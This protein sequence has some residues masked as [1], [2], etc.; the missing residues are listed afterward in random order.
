MAVTSAPLL[1]WAREK[2]GL[3]VEIVAA[4][5]ATRDLVHDHRLLDGWLARLRSALTVPA[6]WQPSWARDVPR[7]SLPRALGQLGP[8][9][10]RWPR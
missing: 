3:V 7:L 8:R 5:E 6:P 9:G 1:D 2:L 4:V 10:S